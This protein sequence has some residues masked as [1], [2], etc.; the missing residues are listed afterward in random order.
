MAATGSDRLPEREVIGEMT[1]VFEFLLALIH[2]FSSLSVMTVAGTDTTANS[3][4]R[5]LHR[6]AELPNV[7][8]TLRREIV[9][10]QCDGNI[11]FEKLIQL[12]YL[13][14]VCRE[15]LRV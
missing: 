7:Q 8:D 4:A 5:M 10:A 14:A 12:P 6:L 1:Y 11:S 2:S 13:N 15:T 3:I 9:E